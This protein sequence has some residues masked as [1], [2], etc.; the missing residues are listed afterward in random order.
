MRTVEPYK[1]DKVHLQGIANVSN[2]PRNNAKSTSSISQEVAK[3]VS[4][5]V[6]VLRYRGQELTRTALLQPRSALLP[7][8]R[9]SSPSGSV[10]GAFGAYTGVKL[11]GCLQ[12]CAGL[13]PKSS[14][15]HQI[16]TTNLPTTLGARLY[17]STLPTE[18]VSSPVNL[19]RSVAVCCGRAS[20]PGSASAHTSCCIVCRQTRELNNKCFTVKLMPL[21][22]ATLVQS[23]THTHLPLH[24]HGVNSGSSGD[25][26]TL[27]ILRTPQ[28]IL[29]LTAVAKRR[30]SE[31]HEAR[32]GAYLQVSSSPSDS[33]AG[34][35]GP[36]LLLILPPLGNLRCALV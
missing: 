16:A 21:V 34:T 31:K 14:R 18:Q 23:S 10:A 11:I 1:R 15:H 13:Q 22:T 28:N 26:S 36:L 27:Q 30:P 12:T 35:P 8:P 24:K 33:F 20:S 32:Q 25:P 6:H 4:G 29:A 17:L 7:R 9:T 19:P 5:Q 3:C 2:P